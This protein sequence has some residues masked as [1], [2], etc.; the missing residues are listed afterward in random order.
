[1]GTASSPSPITNGQKVSFDPSSAENYYSFTLT[2][3]GNVLFLGS[4]GDLRVITR[5]A[6]YD[7]DLNLVTTL[8]SGSP[9]SLQAG[10]YSI[11]PV[12][13]E[14]GTFSVTS[15]AMAGSTVTT[16]SDDKYIVNDTIQSIAASIDSADLQQLRTLCS[17]L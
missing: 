1:M 16:G 5:T 15:T 6:V 7:T 10:T 2:E 17:L 14:G 8:S 11:F 13:H 12:D 4:G 3:S 9:E